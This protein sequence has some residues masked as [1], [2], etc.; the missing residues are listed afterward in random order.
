MNSFF[1][2]D[3]CNRV[4]IANSS[5]MDTDFI[6]A[7]YVNMTIPNDCVNRYIA[8]QGPLPNTIYEFWR[9]VQQE[10]SNFIVMLTTIFERGRIKC[11]QYWPHLNEVMQLTETFSIELIDETTDDTDSFVLRNILLVDDA[12]SPSWFLVISHNL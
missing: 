12:V 3:D 1:I 10:S 4:V 8:T 7:N 6:N 9:M 5:E 11:E 2:L